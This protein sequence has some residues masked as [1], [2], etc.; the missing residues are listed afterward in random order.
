MSWRRLCLPWKSFN[1]Y[2]VLNFFYS[3]RNQLWSWSWRSRRW[4]SMSWGSRSWRST[5]LR[6]GAGCPGGASPGDEGPGARGEGAGCQGAGGPKSKRSGSWRS[7]RRRSENLI[8]LS[9]WEAWLIYGWLVRQVQVCYLNKS[10]LLTQCCQPVLYTEHVLYLQNNYRTIQNNYRTI[11]MY[12]RWFCIYRTIT[13]PL[14]GST[15]ESSQLPRCPSS[16]CQCTVWK[17]IEEI[18]IQNVQYYQ[19]PPLDRVLS[20]CLYFNP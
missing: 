3:K 8:P 15:V 2:V 17:T 12:Y 16:I 19:D 6:S 4:K 14:A 20:F 13:E 5:S 7:R 18:D 10:P 9:S 1:F 11:S